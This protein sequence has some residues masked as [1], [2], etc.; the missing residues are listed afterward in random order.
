M[1]KIVQILMCLVIFPK[2]ISR[3]LQFLCSS[4]VLKNKETKFMLAY[5]CLCFKE[6]RGWWG[7][8]EIVLKLP[9]D[10]N[11]SEMMQEDSLRSLKYLSERA[12]PAKY[13]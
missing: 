12:V 4:C 6:A 2:H 11:I 8:G 1:T 13:Q 3:A 5:S 10:Q 9:Q 7:N